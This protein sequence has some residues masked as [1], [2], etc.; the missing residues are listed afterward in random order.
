MTLSTGCIAKYVASIKHETPQFHIGSFDIH[1]GDR[2][3]ATAR[4]CAELRLRLN[5]AK[6]DSRS[7]GK[8]G[9]D[10]AAAA[11]AAAAADAAAAE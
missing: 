4:S 5:F 10:G 11:A 8:A 6:S 2:L 3:D 1:K 9:Q 7:A